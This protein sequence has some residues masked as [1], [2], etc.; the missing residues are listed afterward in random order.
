VI[1]LQAP[2]NGFQ[3]KRRLKTNLEQ[4]QKQNKTISKKQNAIF[5]NLDKPSH[6]VPTACRQRVMQNEEKTNKHNA[7]TKTNKEALSGLKTH[8]KKDLKSAENFTLLASR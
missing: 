1:D 3:S 4:K 5:L 2:L 7:E 8:L 6:N